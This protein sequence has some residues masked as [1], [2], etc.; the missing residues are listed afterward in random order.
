MTAAAATRAL[1]P[2]IG[3]GGA[4]TVSSMGSGGRGLPRRGLGGIDVSPSQ[5]TDGRRKRGADDLA[6]VTVRGLPD[7]EGGGEDR[8]Q[9]VEPLP[10]GWRDLGVGRRHGRECNPRRC[11]CG[12]TTK[13]EAQ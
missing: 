13:R 1:R 10:Y 3:S 11:W 6:P 5:L 7:A 4:L 9:E 2:G 12:G 8:Q